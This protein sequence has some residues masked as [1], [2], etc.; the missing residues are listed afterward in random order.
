MYILYVYIYI[1]T[2]DV[3]WDYIWLINGCAYRYTQYSDGTMRSINGDFKIQLYRL[4]D[5]DYIIL[6]HILTISITDGSGEYC[7]L[8]MMIQL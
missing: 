8:S 2:S 3:L 7:I 5:I 4:D 1:Y 6:Y